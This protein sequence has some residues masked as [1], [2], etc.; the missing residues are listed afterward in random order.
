[1]SDPALLRFTESSSLVEGDTV[2]LVNGIDMRAEKEYSE[3]HV[4]GKI[5]VLRGYSR[6]TGYAKVYFP[7]IEIHVWAHPEELEKVQ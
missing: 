5:G 2:R 4:L 6:S 1:M 7:S 3:M